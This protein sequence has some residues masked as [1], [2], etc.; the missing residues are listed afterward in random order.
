MLKGNMKKWL[1]NIKKKYKKKYKNR[2]LLFISDKGY[3]ECIVYS[4]KEYKVRMSVYEYLLIEMLI[5]KGS[6][7]VEE[8]IIKGGSDVG[9]VSVLDNSNNIK[10]ILDSN[11]IKDNRDT[12]DN[13]DTSDNKDTKDNKDT[14]TTNNLHTNNNNTNNNN[15]NNNINILFLLRYSVLDNLCCYNLIV[16]IEGVIYLNNNFKSEKEKI[17]FKKLNIISNKGYG[18]N[19]YD[20]SGYDSSGYGYDNGYGSNPYGSNPYINKYIDTNTINTNNTTNVNT[21]NNINNVYVQC[22]VVSV[23]KREKR[24]SVNCLKDKVISK[25]GCS[26]SKVEEII[27]VLVEKG[28]IENVVGCSGKVEEI[29]GVLVEKGIIEKYGEECI[30]VV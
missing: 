14:N 12:K 6:I 21:T 18:S 27:G 17:K 11:N 28:I 19:G 26:V 2:K 24:L 9:D 3:I 22:F 15:T 5:E 1:E 25:V 4:N 16:I 23:M 29:I 10:D 13:K 30:Y 20:S 7:K 8:Y